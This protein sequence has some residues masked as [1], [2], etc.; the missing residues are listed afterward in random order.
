M[1]LDIKS[2]ITNS[3]ALEKNKTCSNMG[4]SGTHQLLGLKKVNFSKTQ[5][6]KM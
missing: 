6:S 3:K 1:L 2:S 5:F 4:G